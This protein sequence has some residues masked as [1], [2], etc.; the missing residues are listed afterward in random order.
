MPTL[1]RLRKRRVVACHTSTDTLVS[2][3]KLT[4]EEIPMNARSNKETARS[5]FENLPNIGDLAIA[6]T[7]FASEIRFHYPL[8]ELE[9]IESIKAYI[10]AVRAAFPDIR[11]RVEDLFGEDDLVACRWILVGTQTG[12]FRGNPPSGKQVRVPGN[13][14]F[15]MAHGQIQEMWVAFNPNLLL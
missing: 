11:F 15:R 3:L 9:G 8:G 2:N 10:T 1:T 13:T 14:I 4:A 5:Y 12:E 7:L 6:D